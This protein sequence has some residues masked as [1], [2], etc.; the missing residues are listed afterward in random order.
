MHRPTRKLRNVI[1]KLDSKK[2]R[3]RK[4]G[5]KAKRWKLAIDSY[6]PLSKDFEGEAPAAP[7]PK[8]KKAVEAEEE[9]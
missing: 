6:K 4:S 2:A 8:K 5:S 1:A 9:S 3:S 7:P